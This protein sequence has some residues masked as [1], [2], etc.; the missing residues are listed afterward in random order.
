MIKV[1]I[2]GFGYS[3]DKIPSTLF[4][5]Y[6]IYNKFSH[7]GYDCEILTDINDFRYNRNVYESISF[8]KVD[9]E[10]LTFI[11]NLKRNP[12]YYNYIFNKKGLIDKL[13]SIKKRDIVIIYYTG[14]GNSKGIKIPSGE[15]FSFEQFKT[16][17]INTSKQEIYIIIDCCHASGMKL[18]YRLEKNDHGKFI[19]CDNGDNYKQNAIIIA[20]SQENEKSAAVK[21]TSLFTKYFVEFL[22]QDDTKLFVSMVDHID[23][24][25]YS[26]SSNKQQVNVYSSKI[27]IPLVHTYMFSPKY[28]RICCQYSYLAIDNSI[29]E[30]KNDH[31]NVVND[32]DSESSDKEENQENNKKCYIEDLTIES[33]F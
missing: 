31:D 28:I 3:D 27:I 19:E 2:I 9:R 17:L 20:S 21:H 12:P 26:Y 7:M 11:S 25:L 22:D 8:K 10:M 15:I 4:D 24:N 23:N 13:K 6:Q 29:F 18:N 1:I 30:E 16:L 33:I 32:S 5:L 14:H